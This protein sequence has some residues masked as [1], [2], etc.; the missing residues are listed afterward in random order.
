MASALF[1]SKDDACNHSKIL[2]TQQPLSMMFLSL[3]KHIPWGGHVSVEWRKPILRQYIPVYWT[4]G[5]HPIFANPST[6]HLNSMILR[7]FHPHLCTHQ[8]T[9]HKDFLKANGVKDAFF[10]FII[11]IIKKK[12]INHEPL[13]STQKASRVNE[14]WPLDL[15]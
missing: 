7:H 12:K 14:Q 2:Q 9:L 6:L 10:F 1:A 11:I 3:P 15:L 13:S 5:W 4:D 8:K